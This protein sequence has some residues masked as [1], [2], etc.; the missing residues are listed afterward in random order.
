M[1]RLGISINEYQQRRETLMRGVSDD[2]VLFIP[3][4][5]H[6]SRTRSSEYPYRQCSDFYYLTGF[7]EPDAVLVLIPGESKP[8]LLYCQPKNPQKERWQGLLLGTDAAVE[9]LGVDL[10]LSIET[11]DKHLPEIINH[12][13]VYCVQDNLQ[14]MQRLRACMGDK[15]I[16]P[17]EPLIAKQRLYK[18][19]A[20]IAIIQKAVDITVKAHQQ[21][22]KKVKPGDFEYQLAAEYEYVFRHEGAESPAYESIVGGGKNACILHY[23]ANADKL[24]DQTLVLVDAAA[25]Y[26]NYASD[27]T[28]TYPVNGRF[29]SQQKD[30]YNI[31]LRAQESAIA[32][33]KP[34]VIWDDLQ[35]ICV[36]VL[37]QGMI[38]LGILSGSLDEVIETKRYRDFYMHS[39]GHWLGL[40]VHDVGAY[41]IDNQPVLFAPHMVMTMEPGIYIDENS[42]CDPMWWGMGIR[43]EDDIVIT[44]EGCTVLSQAC[45]KTVAA[46]EQL[47]AE[48]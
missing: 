46:I 2:A 23:R 42:A 26:Q 12:K 27:I 48:S 10:A 31:V 16:R 44:N 39:S 33:M 47:M 3:A 19:P 11:L 41:K 28:R 7:N 40:D 1:S 36:K 18:S 20:E 9:R 32:A 38:D 43:I 25:E 29:T 17:L 24:E 35:A 13:T 21:G 45:P 6:L 15:P 30:L 34:G 4:A 37:S 8:V 22:M 5:H 14:F